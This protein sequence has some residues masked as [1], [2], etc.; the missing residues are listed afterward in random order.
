MNLDLKLVIESSTELL[1]RLKQPVSEQGYTNLQ[2]GYSVTAWEKE[3]QSV[4]YVSVE[5]GHLLWETKDNKSAI[6]KIVPKKFDYNGL[7]SKVKLEFVQL[8]SRVKNQLRASRR[9]N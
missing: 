9:Y 4:L 8:P 7:T 5:Y 1:N 3:Q 2:V 6:K